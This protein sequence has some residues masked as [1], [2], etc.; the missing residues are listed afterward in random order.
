M[1]LSIITV[2]L[3]NAVGLEK[4]IESVCNQ[5][6]TD[7]EYIIIDGGSNDESTNI[8]NQYSD[9][10]SYCISEADKGIYHAMNKGIKQAYGEYCLFL[11]SGDYLFNDKTLE[12]VFNSNVEADIIYGDRIEI[13]HNKEVGRKVYPDKLSFYHFYIDSLPHQATFIKSKLFSDIGYYNEK[14]EYASDWEFFLKAIVN[15]N[16]SY[17]HINQFISCFD[18]M[19]VSNKKDNYNKMNHERMEILEINYSLFKDD[20]EA[21]QITK[22]KL[23]EI[24]SYSLFFFLKRIVYYFLKSFRIKFFLK[25]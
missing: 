8:I 7:F 19:G 9:K 3:N 17:H 22:R 1:K 2:N 13:K 20:Y 16:C 18:R 21:I 10:I 12:I 11:N 25:K 23:K 5:T 14:L 15:S 6:F 4:T 24:Q